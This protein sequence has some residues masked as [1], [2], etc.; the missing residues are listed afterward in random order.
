ME[1][2]ILAFSKTLLSRAT[3]NDDLTIESFSQPERKD[4]VDASHGGDILTF[5]IDVVLTLNCAVSKTFVLKLSPRI[6]TFYSGY[7]T[8]LWALTVYYST[9]EDSI[10]LAT[11]TGIDD[12][13][14]K[15][16]FNYNMLNIQ[17]SRKITSWCEQFSL[18]TVITELTNF[19]E[20]SSS[21]IDLVLVSNKA[22]A[23][24]SGLGDPFLQQVIRYHCSAFG[25]VN[26]SK[27]KRE[28]FTRR[29]WCYEQGNYN[30]LRGVK[31]WLDCD[32]QCWYKHIC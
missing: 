2:D 29:I 23:M 3:Q 7:S 4:R 28:S 25:I 14:T 9:V 17:S 13:I 19:T 15:G 31:N 12:I 8:G 16:D 5:I 1:F 20:T 6:S 26:F 11:D 30:L 24:L 18:A 21:L 27:P 22:H 32:T 10:N